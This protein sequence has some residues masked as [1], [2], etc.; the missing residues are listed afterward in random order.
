M[1]SVPATTCEVCHG[2]LIENDPKHSISLEDNTPWCKACD[3]FYCVC[4]ECVGKCE[5]LGVEVERRDV[6]RI[7]DRDPEA[8]IVPS[9]F[10]TK[11][12]LFYGG[13]SRHNGFPILLAGSGGNGEPH[14]HVSNREIK[15]LTGEK[16]T[17]GSGGLYSFWYCHRCRRK[18]SVTD[19]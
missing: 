7:Q 2:V 10:I 17:G 1:A 13:I 16:I 6:P 9:R 19:K 12:P 18:F 8:R 5:F 15:F 3:C 11:D 4:E 14:H